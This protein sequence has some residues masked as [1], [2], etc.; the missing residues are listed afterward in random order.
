MFLFNIIAYGQVDIELIFYL[1]T[2]NILLI[3]SV[4]LTTYFRKETQKRGAPQMIKHG[5]STALVKPCWMLHLQDQTGWQH[6]VC[7]KMLWQRLKISSMLFLKSSNHQKWSQSRSNVLETSV[8]KPCWSS[9]FDGVAIFIRI[10]ISLLIKCK[11]IV[12]VSTSEYYTQ[13]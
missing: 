1:A 6:N 11:R 10:R 12:M 3:T 4:G 8:H 5:L 13:N 2:L 7:E 9:M